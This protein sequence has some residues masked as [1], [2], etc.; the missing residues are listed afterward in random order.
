LAHIVVTGGN[1][2]AAKDIIKVLV[3]QGHQITI[4]DLNPIEK[5]KNIF[6]VECDLR[7]PELFKEVVGKV[8]DGEFGRIE[9][10]VN[11]A[12]APRTPGLIKSF[13]KDLLSEWVETF[14]I[15]VF[16]PY[17]F[18]VEVAENEKN[19]N[20]L[21]SIINISS[22]LSQYVSN[23]ESA[24]Y[25]SSK[26]ALESISRILAIGLGKSHVRVNTIS[27]GYIENKAGSSNSSN[28]ELIKETLESIRII[29]SNLEPTDVGEVVAFLI[30][31]EAKGISGQVIVIDQGLGIR[32]TL[33]ASIKATQGPR[34]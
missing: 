18:S 16:A 4:L 15:Q 14:A 11:L 10:I 13:T 3:S 30:S 19:R 6:F 21:K 22:I 5:S 33:D 26:A 27:L 24:S 1:S 29:D 34:L 17:F 8:I 28:S 25:H 23:A 31:P 9:A 2:R 20:H 7:R 12:R 32:E